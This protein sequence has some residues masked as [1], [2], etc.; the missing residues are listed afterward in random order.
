[1]QARRLLTSGFGAAHRVPAA[2]MKP[3]VD[4]CTLETVAGAQPRQRRVLAASHGHREHDLTCL[5]MA[6]S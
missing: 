2:V 4:F 3:F 1:M 6:M 5:S